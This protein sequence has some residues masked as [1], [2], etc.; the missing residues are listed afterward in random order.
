VAAALILHTNKDELYGY[1]FD[2]N[3]GIIAIGDIP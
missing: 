1:D 3:D 2:D